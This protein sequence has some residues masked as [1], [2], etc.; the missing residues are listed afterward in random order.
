MQDSKSGQDSKPGQDSKSWIDTKIIALTA[1]A[2]EDDRLKAIRHGSNDFVRK[3]F[4]ESEIFEMLHKHLGVRYV[5]EEEQEDLKP[6]LLNEKANDRKLTVYINNLPQEIIVRLEEATELS[7]TAMID[8]V[9][10]DIRIEDAQLAGVLS[11]LAANFAYDKILALIANSNDEVE[12]SVY[13]D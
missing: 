8:Q 12:N 3:P 4:R 1:N 6:T 13:L 9:I 7:D 11:E 10:E 2:F 5:Y